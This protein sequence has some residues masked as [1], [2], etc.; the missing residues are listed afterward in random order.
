MFSSVRY[1]LSSTQGVR[2]AG[3]G[4]YFNPRR[5]CHLEDECKWSW[6]LFQMTAAATL[7]LR[8]RSSVAVLDTARSPPSA[9]ERRPAQ[10]ERFAVGMRTCWKYAGPAPRVQ[11]SARNAIL[12]CIRWGTRSQFRTSRSTGVMEYLPQPVTIRAAAFITISSR[13]I[14]CIVA[15]YKTTLQ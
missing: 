12:N 13:R 14:T 15:L 6:R 1:T 8:W 11:M 9:E 2:H 10:P 5:N 7:K 3:S 4:G